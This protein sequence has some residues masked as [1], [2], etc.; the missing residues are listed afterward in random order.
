M[1]LCRDQGLGAIAYSPLAEGFLSGKYRRGKSAASVKDAPANRRAIRP[2]MEAVF[3]ERNQALLDGL[4]AFAASSRQS[5]AAL[6]VA[7]VLHQPG[8]SAA[9]VGARELAQ[10]Q[11]NLQAA[12]LEIAEA[13]LAR[14]NAISTWRD[15]RTPLAIPTAT[16]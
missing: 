3:T 14:L 12:D 7:W 8:V 16:R 6:A 11:E 4:E 1:H 5:V 13:D 10:L 15:D 9:L 2:E